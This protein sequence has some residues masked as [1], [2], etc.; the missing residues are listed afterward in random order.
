MTAE[1]TS[2]MLFRRYGLQRAEMRCKKEW[3]QNLFTLMMCGK[4]HML[5]F[6]YA[7]IFNICFLDTREILDIY[8]II[9]YRRELPLVLQDIWHAIQRVDRLLD[10]QHPDYKAAK[11]T[12]STIFNSIQSQSYESATHLKKQ[13][14]EWESKYSVLSSRS[15]IP[16]NDLIT[17]LGAAIQTAS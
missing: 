17:Q 1:S 6:A 11:G 4:V 2:T 12:F 13:L 14:L 16:L 5:L 3:R 9:H 8:S 10:K 7:I 15:A